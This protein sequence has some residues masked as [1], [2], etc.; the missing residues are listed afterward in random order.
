MNTSVASSTART[1]TSHEARFAALRGLIATGTVWYARVIGVLSIV[2]ALVPSIQDQLNDLPDTAYAALWFL[3]G[4]PSLGFGI[5]MLM[6]ASALRRRKRVA[7][8]LLVFELVLVGPIGTYAITCVVAPQYATPLDQLSGLYLVILGV[9]IV[10]LAVVTMARREFVAKGDPSN[11]RLALAVL[12]STIVLSIGLGTTL[13]A[14]TDTSTSTTLADHLMYTLQRGLAETGQWYTDSGVQVPDAVNVLL[15]LLGGGLLLLTAFALFRPRLGQELLTGEDEHDL[16]ELL[17]RHGERDSLGYF[18]LRRDKAVVWSP[19]R[20]AA[21]TYRV[22]WGVSLAGG[23][24]IGDPEAWPG[25]VCAWLEEARQHA[26]VPAV[27]GASEEG[28]RVFARHGLDALELGDEA[29]VEVAD[30]NLDGRPMRVV[31]QAYNRVLRAGYTTRIRRHEAIP[32][33][34]M[35]AL[36][37]AA[38]DW[39]DGPT[40]R[41]F[42]MALGRL[43]DPA[44]GRCAMVECYDADDRLRALLSF[45][46]WGERGLSLDLMRR[47]RESD[48]GLV[49]FMV[50]Q[51]IQA[52]QEVGLERISLNFA[53]FRSV[54]ER[55]SRLGAGPA[56]RAWRGI[57]RFFSRWW[58]IESL[59]RAN[60]KYRPMWI[61]RFVCFPTARDLTRIGIAAGRAEGFIT[62]PGMPALF[63][64]RRRRHSPPIIRSPDRPESTAHEP[65]TRPDEPAT[66]PD[67]PAARPD[68]PPTRPDGPAPPEAT[69]PTRQAP[70]AES[71]SGASRAQDSARR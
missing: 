7:W 40:E 53:M 26:W 45:A 8:W 17:V 5:L 22:V 38:D 36:V 51:L 59:Y 12:A 68:A 37:R 18:S 55:G 13:V 4:I 65:A 42:S 21:I 15:N 25:A 67:K 48:N 41:G 60:A 14:S 24:P 33:D 9:L 30:F 43:G 16:R 10:V 62:A 39:R 66:G 1:T 19:T 49:E 63:D 70:R 23:D 27:M 3:V 50:I 28:A 2:S 29:V 34:E 61:P 64:R 31:R 32:E 46:P 20:K 47:D 69:G 6:L 57:L 58:Q 56:L 35:A 71:S 44:D 54:F 11:P 52:A